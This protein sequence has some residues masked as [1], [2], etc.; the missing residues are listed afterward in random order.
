[1][2][3]PLEVWEGV[4][5]VGS[6]IG[7]V[8]PGL[9]PWPSLPPPGS[10]PRTLPDPLP[11]PPG[12]SQDPSQTPP[13]GSPGPSQD[14]PGPSQGSPG[15]SQGPPRPLPGVPRGLPGPSQRPP[16]TQ[17]LPLDLSDHPLEDRSV[18]R[19]ADVVVVALAS[20][21]PTSSSSSS[22]SSVVVS[23]VE[24]RASSFPRRRCGADARCSGR[25]V[26]GWC[27]QDNACP[28]PQTRMGRCIPPT[29]Y[30]PPGRDTHLHS[31]VLHTGSHA[32]GCSRCAT[33]DDANEQSVVILDA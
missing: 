25:A 11:G 18:V 24:P 29:D 32:R 12:P 6:R 9:A 14:L 27:T 10:H 31:P 5:L 33:L 26:T 23:R 2:A 8:W 20:S 13:R 21:S 17:D 15:P 30:G 3:K 4:E 16:R 19:S 22:S 28:L 1:M 7:T